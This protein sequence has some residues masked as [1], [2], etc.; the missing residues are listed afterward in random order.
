MRFEDVVGHDAIKRSLIQSVKD[1]H[2]S[3]AMLFGG[4]P[5]SGNLAL[6]LAFAQYVLCKN[7]GEHDSCGECP[8]CKKMMHL[9]HP[10][11]HFSFPVILRKD[12]ETSSP[13]SRPF[14][15]AVLNNPYIS[16]EEWMEALGLVLKKEEN[17]ERKNKQGVI[18]VEES[19]QI[20]QRLSLKS[21]E[22]G[23]KILLMWLPEYMNEKAANKLLKTIEEPSPRTLIFLVSES[24]ENMLPTILSRVQ[25]LSV[26]RVSSEDL[27]EYV[28]SFE[29][30]DQRTAQHISRLA[31]GSV[32]EAHYL[33][34]Q[35]ETNTLLFEYFR[36]WMR[37]CFKADVVGAQEWVDSVSK[38]NRETQKHLVHYSLHMLRQCVSGTYTS[39][40]F[41]QLDGEELKFARD[42]AP[43]VIPAIVPLSK[44][45]DDAHYHLER[46]GNAKFI[47]MDIS[48]RLMRLM[49]TSKKRPV[50]AAAQ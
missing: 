37:L 24:W 38:E 20:V 34:F 32:R 19:K 30:V 43:F 26:P 1:N 22:G 6:A 21:Y 5:G 14:R 4:Y 48:F 36:D 46:N 25:H 35:G 16:Y 7:P 45:L 41:M 17:R 15:E 27:T 12:L 42:F 8:N 29:G 50:K 28:A 10:D 33:I 18:G 40:D 2:V 31:D 23:Y 47:F 3:H 13:Y 11:V 49:H 9:S 39:T 44:M